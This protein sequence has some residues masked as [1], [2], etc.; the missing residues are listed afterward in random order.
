MIDAPW[1]PCGMCGWFAL[2][3]NDLCT[4]ADWLNPVSRHRMEREV[5]DRHTTAVRLAAAR[6]LQLERAA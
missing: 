6:V 4:C 3:G 5:R 1:L 2:P